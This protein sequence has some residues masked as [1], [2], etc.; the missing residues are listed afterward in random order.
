MDPAAVERSAIRALVQ[1][2]PFLPTEELGP[3]VTE[4]DCPICLSEYGTGSPNDVPVKLPCGHILGA[5]CMHTWLNSGK[6]TCPQCRHQV[7]NRPVPLGLF[8]HQHLQLLEV[9][10]A[11]RTFLT[12]TYWHIDQSY[13]AFRRWANGDTD[14]MNSMAYRRLA[15]DAIHTIETLAQ[16]I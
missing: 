14:D 1:S 13:Y 10:G 8:S 7:F 4:K 6:N 12:E 11:A 5:D 9:R 2:L 15:L 3:D 16:N